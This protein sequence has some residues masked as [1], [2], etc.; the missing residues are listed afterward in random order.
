ML[1]YSHRHRFVFIH[2]FKAAGISVRQALEPYAYRPDGSFWRRLRRRLGLAAPEPLAALGPHAFAA[3]VRA[4]LP[5]KTFRRYFKFAFVRN[6]W[7]WQV[8]WYHYIRQSPSH[9]LHDVVS[10]MRDFDEYVTWRVDNDRRLQRDFVVDARGRLLVDFL[11]RFERLE[12]DFAAVCA[13]IGI[14][15]A[16]PHSNRSRHRDYRWYYTDRTRELV[17]LAWAEDVEAFGYRY[18]PAAPAAPPVA[19]PI[20]ANLVPW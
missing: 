5:E 1:C 2:V 15:G 9:Y 13:H 6:P 12:E 17:E 20:P 18:E 14:R 7:D 16:L 3:D 11:G 19:A 4:A 10:R 8:S